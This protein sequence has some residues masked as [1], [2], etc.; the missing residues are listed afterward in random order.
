MLPVS[1]LILIAVV[2]SV[3]LKKVSVEYPVAVLEVP[4][5]T[6]IMEVE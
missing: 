1:E 4:F 3:E 6:N 5:A 2:V